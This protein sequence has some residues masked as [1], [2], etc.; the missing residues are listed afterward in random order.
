MNKPLQVVGNDNARFFAHVSKTNKCW[1]WTGTQWGKGYGKF[2][3][4]DKSTQQ[5]VAIT[6]HRYSYKMHTGKIPTG[7][8]VDHLCMNK[9]CV[10]PKHLEVVTNRENQYRAKE[11][12]GCWPIQARKPKTIECVVCGVKVE[13]VMYER[14]RYCGNACRCKAQRARKLLN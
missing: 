10:N 2:Y 11:I 7:M 4:W 9:L 13:S 14:R 8:Q 5:Q 1:Q 12:R 3:L 6:A